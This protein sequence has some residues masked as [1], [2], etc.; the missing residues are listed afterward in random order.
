M[1]A[2][3]DRSGDEPLLLARSVPGAVV[4]V[5]EQRAIAA[6][7][8]RARARRDGRAARR[9]VPASAGGARRRSRHRRRRTTCRIAGCRSAGCASRCRA[10]SRA[11]ALVIARTAS[12]GRHRGCRF[13]RCRPSRSRR[14]ARRARARSSPSGRG[15]AV[16]RPG[17]RRGRHRRARALQAALDG[18]GLERQPAADLSRSPSVRRRDLDRMAAAVRDDRRGWRRDDR[19]GRDAAACRCGRCRSPCA[20]V[21]LDG[22][23]SSRRRRFRPWLLDAAARGARSERASRCGIASNTA[24]SPRCAAIVGMLPDAAARG[25]GTSRRPLLLRR[26]SM[27]IGAWPSRSCARRFRRARTAECRAIA[28]AT[29]AHF[30]RLLV[31]RAQVQHAVTPDQI[32]ARVEF[33]GEDRVRAALAAGKGA[34][35]FTGHFGY[36]ELQGLA[37]PLVLP[38]MSVLARPLDNPYLHALLEQMR[39][40][41]RQ[42]ASST[43]GRAAPRAA[44]AQ[45][46]RVRGDADR[47]A[48]PRRRRGARSSSSIGR[49]R[50]RRR[51]PRWRCAPARR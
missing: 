40:R 16:A 35:I 31:V 8:R 30:G 25:L 32:R 22:R 20:A 15:P 48:H 43:A 13:R 47:P 4:L 24:W 28:R 23:R 34:I 12:A 21:P 36:W 5:C 19:E 1:L 6:R 11:H 26:R 46:E 18:G 41:D 49:R 45:R 17:R 51:W 33:E 37:H 44:R 27:R 29:F 3:L 9:R 50:R 42:P 2:D 7:A 10:L 14:H 38:P 39:M